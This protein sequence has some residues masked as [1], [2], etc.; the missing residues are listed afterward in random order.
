MICSYFKRK[1]RVNGVLTESHEW[2]GRLRMNWEHGCPKVWN[3]GT[4]DEDEAQRLLQEARTKA[5]KRYHG[6]LPPEQCE[7]AREQPLNELLEAFLSEL[8][9]SGRTEGTLK[10]YRNLAVLF[11]RCGWQRITHVTERSFRQWRVTSKLSGETKNDLLKNARNFFGWMLRS[12]M[13]IENPFL[14][15][16]SVKVTPKDYRRALST[17]EAQRLLRVATPQRAAVYLMAM[18]SGLRRKELQGLKVGDFAFDAP[19]PF[20]RVPAS[21]TKNREDATL[22]LP[23]EVISLIRSVLPDNPMPFEK[24]FA[25]MVPRLPR[26]KKDLAQAGIPFE[27]TDGRRIDLHSLRLTFCMDAG[28]ACGGDLRLLQ[29]VMRHSDIRTTMRH[30]KDSSRLP[31]AKLIANLPSLTAISGTQVSTQTGTQT[32]VAEGQSLSQAVVGGRA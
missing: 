12:R 8:R 1:R 24:V 21:I 10:K 7:E 2:F 31:T 27:D 26:F 22:W 17:E 25:G 19:K 32:P 20:V 4:T 14:F 5:E 16:E 9:S 3:L 30:Y 23:D 29:A 6:L 18:R 11:R 13:V 28:D 15:I